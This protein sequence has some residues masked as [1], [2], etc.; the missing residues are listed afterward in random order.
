MTGPRDAL[1]AAGAI[2][3]IASPKTDS[4]QGWNKDEKGDTF[5]VGVPI[6]AANPA[7]FDALLLPGGVRSPDSLRMNNRASLFVRAMEIAQRPIAA[8]CHGPWML[9]QTGYVRGRKLTSWPS[10]RVDIVNAGGTWLDQAV[11]VDDRLVTS[12]RPA[13]VPYFN[14]A[15]IELFSSVA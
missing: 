9:V 7:E 15:M 12:R 10:L 4:V 8:I 5:P 14:Q 11:V 2:T 3:T 13:D 6:A 1:H